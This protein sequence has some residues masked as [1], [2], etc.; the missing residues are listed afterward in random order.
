MNDKESFVRQES[1][2]MI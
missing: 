2:S 1:G